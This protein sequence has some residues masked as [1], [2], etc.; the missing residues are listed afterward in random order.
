MALFV[1]CLPHAQSLLLSDFKLLAHNLVL[2]RK[3]P[4]QIVKVMWSLEGFAQ[5]LLSLKLFS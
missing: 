2:Q 1:S 5:A 4:K 3:K